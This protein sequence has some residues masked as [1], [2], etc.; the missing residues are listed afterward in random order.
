[1][2]DGSFDGYL[3]PGMSRET[4]T[5]QLRI[6][7]CSWKF[8]SWEGLVYSQ[9]K[10]IDYLAE[11]ARQYDTVEVDQWFWSLFG[12]DTVA[13]P[14]RKD[15]DAY[16]AA[17][18]DSFLFTVKA[19]NS[20]TLTHFYRKN[21]GEP[22]RRNPHFLSLEL[23]N[24]FM[25]TLGPLRSK[26]GPIMF[27]FEYLNKQKMGGLQEFLHRLAGFI[28]HLPA[29]YQYAIE[30]RN[31]Q[32]LRSEYFQF[33]RRHGLAHVF[34][35]GYYM[36]NVLD[37]YRRHGKDLAGTTV[38]RLHG[39]DRQG[40][41]KRTGKKWGQAVAPKDEEIASVAAMVDELL[42]RGLQ[43]VVNVNNHYEG[44]A[45]ITIQKLRAALSGGESDR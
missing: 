31:P 15:V 30:P 9:A 1:M 16:D 27:Q 7:T 33:L 3:I 20:I 35:Q 6:G 40:I 39:P 23:F 18:P 19:P 14:K 13:L 17:V 37:V 8:P 34:L 25:D 45:P 12:E 28:T 32:Y 38:I 44:S 5:G 24:R 22:L 36:P 41:E 29:G 42:S 10:G 4:T 43:V 26:V 11:Y 21:K 2:V